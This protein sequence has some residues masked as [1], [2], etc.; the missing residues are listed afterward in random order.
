MPVIQQARKNTG[1]QEGMESLAM[2]TFD[3]HMLL[4]LEHILTAADCLSRSI[5]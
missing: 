2:V 3:K 4:L 1:V 5:E